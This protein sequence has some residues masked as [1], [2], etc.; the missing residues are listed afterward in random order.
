M[1]MQ[2][3][4]HLLLGLLLCC[5]AVPAAAQG[6][7]GVYAVAFYNLENLF[8]TED[9]PAN[10]GDDEFLPSGPY[11]WTE[12]KYRQKLHNIA[13]VISQLA[14]E[15]CPGGPAVI[16]ISEVENERVIRD[17]V[18]TEP[19]ASMG[20]KYIHH[21]GPDRRGIDVA[22]LYNPRLFTVTDT[23]AYRYV[24]PDQ[25]D[26]RTRDQL[27]V[28]GRLAGEPVSIIVGHWP[29]RYGGA[30]S[31]PLRDFAAQLARHIADSV[32]Q[33]DPAAKVI[34]MG[35]FNDDPSDNSCAVV[36]EAARSQKTTPQGGYFNATWPLFDRGVGSLC[37]QDKWCLYDQQIISDNFLTR[38]SKDYTQLRYWKTEVFNRPFMTTP[39]GKRKGYPFRTFDGTTFQNGYSDHFPT[40]TY[41]VKRID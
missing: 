25:P 19:M 2:T 39:A 30:K 8:D 35:D 11:Q 34:A 1:T 9:D 21:S 18:A 36:F 28:S 7:V 31:A 22:L 10:P 3:L 26:Y 27:L 40:I 33:A 23:V 4:K 32:R 24:K 41:Y 16:G 38:G 5:V 6:R 13:T 15:H 37:Y 20:L 12:Q 17:L 14:R 29:S